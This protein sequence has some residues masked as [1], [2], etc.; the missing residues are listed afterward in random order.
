VSSA[1]GALVQFGTTI[2]EYAGGVATGIATPA[3]LASIQK[4]TGAM[5]VMGSG[6]TP[7]AV[8]T[9]ANGTLVQ[10]LGTPG[11]WVND[12][13]TLYQFMSASQFLTDGYSFQ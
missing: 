13:G 10:P 6:S 9:S 4:I 11:V 1:N 8:T 7:T 5:V 3:Q 12:A 2:Y